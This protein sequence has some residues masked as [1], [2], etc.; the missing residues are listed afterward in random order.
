MRAVVLSDDRIIEF[1]NENFINIWVSNVELERTPNKRAY[2]AKRRQ[3]GFKP[4][5]R[6]HP[7]MQAIMKGW[8]AHSPSDS[9]VISSKLEVMGRQPVNELLSPG[10]LTQR[11][12]MFLKR[13]LAGKLPGLGEDTPA[14][15][16]TDW[17][18]VL[19]SGHVTTDALKIVLTAEDPEQEVLST[20]RAPGQGYQDYTVVEID[21]TAFENGGWLTIDLWVGDAEAA[22][23]FDLYQGDSILPTEGMPNGALT[24]AWDVPPEQGS[25]IEYYFDQGQVFKLGATGSWF[26]EKGSINGFLAKISVEPGTE[27]GQEPEKVSSTHS[28]QSPEDLMNAFVKAFKNLDSEALHSMITGNAKE[29]LEIDDVPEG[30][31]AQISQMLSQ[32]EVLSSE[33]VGDEF[34]FRLRVPMADR[35]EAT[36][37]MRKIDGVW[38]VYDVN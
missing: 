29:S 9:L 11:Y 24:S 35:E 26:S 23:S 2:I 10:S 1:L 18:A 6:T 7:L 30:M 12:L 16:S 4:F 5:D 3:H 8:K 36:V 13:S 28:Y 19:E 14:S 15:Q 20:F 37:K 33:Y 25:V 27:S 22:G 21:A 17:E 34:H 32:M 38:L 31:R